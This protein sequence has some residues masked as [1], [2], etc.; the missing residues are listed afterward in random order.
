MSVVAPKVILCLYFVGCSEYIESFL[1]AL[2]YIC[3]F[4][5]CLS[6]E[7][8]GSIA[9][10]CVGCLSEVDTDMFTDGGSRRLS[11]RLQNVKLLAGV[12]KSQSSVILVQLE[13]PNSG[14]CA[15]L[16]RAVCKTTPTLSH[17]QYVQSPK[18]NFMFRLCVCGPY[19]SFSNTFS[20]LPCCC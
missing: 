7:V 1:I 17:V 4:R 14:S 18:F 9:L 11:K 6:L 10:G 13:V 20:L 2:N 12:N 19:S 16:S 15:Y 8:M 5:S 3:S